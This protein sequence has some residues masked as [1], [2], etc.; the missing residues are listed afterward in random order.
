MASSEDTVNRLNAALADRYRIKGEIGSGGMATVYLAEDLKHH[1]DV[2]LKVLQPELSAVVG[3]ERFLAEIETTANLQHPN[4]L[5]LFDSG[6]ADGLLFYVMPF[7]EGESLR[8]K[9]DREQQLPVEE[10][11]RI[12]SEVADALQAA[13]ER[14]V[15]HRDIKPANILLS[16]GKPL[17]ADFGIALAVSAAGGGRLTETGLS[18][19]TPHYMSPEQA[20]ADRDPS[21][22]SDVYSLG[23]VLYEML[24]GEPPFTGPTAQAVIAKVLTEESTGPTHYRKT[25]P[26]N[27]DA[28]VRQA[29]EKLPADRFMSAQDFTRALADPGFRF[30][31][32]VAGATTGAWNRLAVGLGAL[33][34]LL[35]LVLGWALLRPESPQPVSRHNINFGDDNNPHAAWV[36]PDGSS[37]LFQGSDVED[38]GS[39]IFGPLLL[40]RRNEIHSTPLPG[41]E[42]GWVVAFSPDGGRIAY[43]TFT[44]NPFSWALRVLSLTGGGTETLIGG[45]SETRSPTA[46]M[47][48][49][50]LGME[51]GPDGYL[52]LGSYWGGVTRIPDNGGELE[53]VT[54]PDTTRGEANHSF[55]QLL[56]DGRT[57]LLRVHRTLQGAVS[58]SQIVAVSL[59]TG[60]RT[61][62]VQGKFARYTPTGYL[63][64]VTA[65]GTLMAVQFDPDRLRLS[66]D[67]VLLADRVRI[68]GDEEAFARARP[69]SLSDEG[70]LLYRQEVELDDGNPLQPSW[71][72]RTGSGEL[73]DSLWYQNIGELCISPDGSRV[74]GSE[75][76]RV[77]QRNDIWVKA[78]GPGGL[79]KLTL[80]GDSRNP[81]WT[82]D[83]RSVTYSSNR[84][85]NFDIW[86]EP[87]DNRGPAVLELDL[88]ESVYEPQWSPDGEWLI[89]RTDTDG[90][91]AG[92]IMAI[93]PRADSSPIALVTTLAQEAGPRL[94]PDGR[95]LAYMSDESGKYEVYVVPF[96][97]TGESRWMVSSNGGGSPVWGKSGQALHY[98]DDDGNLVT[99]EVN[100]STNFQMGGVSALPV[101]RIQEGG[102]GSFFDVSQDG[103]RFLLP[104]LELGPSQDPSR[105]WILVL[106]LFEELQEKVGR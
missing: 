49:Y 23:C 40:R 24:V 74:V 66:G 93:R 36:S 38:T 45:G 53:E 88:D 69:F 100:T 48:Q 25:I 83:G 79:L 64:Y 26:A 47:H 102:W 54:V 11:V 20:S 106:N 78:M 90:P 99:V 73:V 22:A 8:D 28:A 92:D 63:L 34:A 9:L 37:F 71:L 17:V 56:P 3:S 1:R 58:P 27:V 77:Q 95:W 13:H 91:G 15:I 18:L 96:P 32:A 82:P 104:S 67:P 105:S 70:T 29:L 5:P 84:A 103:E 7:V 33:A 51:W 30:G 85:G 81:T 97:N 62:L 50:P 31:E 44:I 72:L 89:F 35:T 75:F 76:D 80:E 14:S 57:L 6:E 43:A 16:R 10:A 52:Y 21:K 98:G 68:A 94:S 60:E 2:A 46:E 65:T 39:V 4:I 86:T 87:A 41:T 61:P 42:G 19:G 59:V 12:A 101:G 55:P